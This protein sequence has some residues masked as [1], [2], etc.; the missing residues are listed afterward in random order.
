M[1][2]KLTAALIA[3]LLSSAAFAQITETVTPNIPVSPADQ[4]I[5]NVRQAEQQIKATEQAVALEK[6][7][8]AEKQAKAKAAANARAAAQRKAIQAKKDEQ[9]AKDQAYKDEMRQLELESKRLDLE[10]KRSNVQTEINLNR[11]KQQRANEILDRQLGAKPVPV[12]PK[13]E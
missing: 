10:A 6:A 3:S 7:R 13:T 2:I 4:Q 1:K 12:T 8:L 9:I 5:L 11:V